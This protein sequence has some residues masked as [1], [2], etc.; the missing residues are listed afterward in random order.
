MGRTIATELKAW[1]ADTE[2]KKLNLLA[3][4][5]KVT[6]NELCVDLIEN[7]TKRYLD[8]AYLCRALRTMSY[9]VGEDTL[10]NNLRVAQHHLLLLESEAVRAA[11]SLDKSDGRS[12]SRAG[13]AMLYNALKGIIA[14]CQKAA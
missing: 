11:Y 10:T 6:T 4:I 12:G 9:Q 5:E 1:E 13:K 8:N 3:H 2:K 7:G 14:D